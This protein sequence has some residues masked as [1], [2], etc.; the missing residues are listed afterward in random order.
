MKAN[1]KW[2][3]KMQLMGTSETGHGILMDGDRNG[4]AAS[5]MEVVLMGM[6]ACSSIDVVDI[7]KTGRQ[8][9][10][11]CEVN[12]TSERAAE[13]PRV[14]TKINAH[15]VVSGNDLNEKKVKRAVELSMEKYCSVAKMLEKA[16]EVTSSYEIVA[17]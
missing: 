6:G 16:A 3:D 1:V 2:I 13:P 15:F 9:I 14:F 7:L 10:L 4:I 5:P 8:N 11:G 12:L 17:K